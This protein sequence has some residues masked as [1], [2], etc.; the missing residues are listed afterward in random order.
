MKK[1]LAIITISLFVSTAAKSQSM[2]GEAVEIFSKLKNL[3]SSY[4]KAQ[5]IYD[6]Y[7]LLE[8]LACSEQ[9]Y[10]DYTGNISVDM[11]T[12]FTKNAILSLDYRI[13][14]TSVQLLSLAKEIISETESGSVSEN[15]ETLTNATENVK[16]LLE[17]LRNFNRKYEKSVLIEIL[18]NAQKKQY[19]S[20]ISLNRYS[21]TSK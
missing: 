7:E 21:K 8:K 12:C 14:S 4:E 9:Q 10:S 5:A 16:K 18:D 3:A 1:I 2:I 11:N 19:N 6:L 13:S 15:Y 20:Y 17:D